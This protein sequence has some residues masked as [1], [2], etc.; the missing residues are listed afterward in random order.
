MIVLVVN[1]IIS[2]I[3][4]IC[5]DAYANSL[6]CTSSYIDMLP[7]LAQPYSEKESEYSNAASDRFRFICRYS[8]TPRLISDRCADCC[9]GEY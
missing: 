4:M 6:S 2:L 1:C 7:E 5:D 8:T 9:L 3:T